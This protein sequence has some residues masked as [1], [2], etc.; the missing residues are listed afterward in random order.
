MPKIKIELVDVFCR[1]TEDIAGAD[2]FYLLGAL[3]GG[4]VTKVIATRPIKINDK[5]TKTFRPEDTVLFEGDI[6]AGQTVK[7]GIKAYDEDVAKD[8]ANKYG[9]T[10]TQISSAVSTAVAAAGGPQ[11]AIAGTVLAAATKAVGLFANLD[12]DDLLDT[13]E[14]EISATGS[15]REE[16]SWVMK[17]KDGI[18]WSTWDYTLRYRITRS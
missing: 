16:R 6:P 9:E 17:K 10:I 11:G 15:S 8:W 13:T 7:G 5:Q 4:E 3:V 14:L 12:K 18:N 2:D 1:Y